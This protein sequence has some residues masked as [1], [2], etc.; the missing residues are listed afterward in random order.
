MSVGYGP[1]YTDIQDPQSIPGVVNNSI[2]PG[3]TRITFYRKDNSEDLE[4][5]G[6]SSSKI[7]G[8]SVWSNI[9]IVENVWGPVIGTSLASPTVDRLYEITRLDLIKYNF[10]IFN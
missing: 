6:Y 2:I 9:L 1:I 7:L 10:R 5:G 8:W 4:M 3:I